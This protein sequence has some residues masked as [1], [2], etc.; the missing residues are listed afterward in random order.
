MPSGWGPG[1]KTLGSVCRGEKIREK[2][3]VKRRK[4][5]ERKKMKKKNDKEKQIL[6][7]GGPNKSVGATW[8]WGF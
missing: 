2:R 4:E 6:I 3:K 1:N 8:S 5:K 7:I